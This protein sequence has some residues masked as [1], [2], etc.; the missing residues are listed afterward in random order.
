[1]SND[2][3]GTTGLTANSNGGTATK[4]K[5]SS[6][7]RRKKPAASKAK[8]STKAKAA[9]KKAPKAKP[10]KVAKKAPTTGDKTYG[11]DRDHDLPWNEKK[12]AVFKALKALKATEPDGSRSAAEVAEKANVTQRDVRHY[13]YH[14]KAAGLVGVTDTPIASAGDNRGYGFYLTAK[15]TKVD[16]AKELKAKE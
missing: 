16:P 8:P 9:K 7:A 1:M 4:A 11:V 14:A 2:A 13:C 3:N 10:A 15:G 5:P 12:V 6:K